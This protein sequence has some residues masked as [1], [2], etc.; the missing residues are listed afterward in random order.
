MH[1]RFTHTSI[2]L[3]VCALLAALS[4]LVFVFQAQGA[5]NHNP[6]GAV[7]VASCDVIAGWTCD[8]DS[9]STPLAV[10]LYKDG[11]YS[12]G[13]W[14]TSGTANGVRSD[15]HAVCGTNEAH[16]FSIPTPTA[17]KDGNQH[18]VNVYGINTGSEGSNT[19]LGSKTLTCPGTL[20]AWVPDAPAAIAAFA[21]S[22][23]GGRIK[24]I[25]TTVQGATSYEVSFDKT[26]WKDVGNTITYTFTNLPPAAT[27]SSFY[28]RAKSSGGVS[29]TAAES[30]PS[31]SSA[32]C[33]V[34]PS[35]S[36][37][38]D[39]VC[40][41]A[42]KAYYSSDASLAGT[43]CTTRISPSKDPEFLP[44]PGRVNWICPGENGGKDVICEATRSEFVGPVTCG[45]YA[46][47]SVTGST[48]GIVWGSG[49]YGERSDFGAAAVHAGLIQPGQTATIRRI[50]VGPST[51]TSSERNGVASSAY[52]QS[53]CAVTI[54]LAGAT[55]GGAQYSC[56]GTLPTNASS[57]TG[58][59]TG[60]TGNTARSF[61]ALGTSAKC[62]YSC[63]SG[64]TWS[65]SAC[66]ASVN[67]CTGTLPANAV[68]HSGD[69]TGLTAN[70][71]RAY[72]AVG[73][74][75]KCEFYCSAGY[76]WSGSSCSPS[77]GFSCTGHV[78]T[79]AVFYSNDDAGLTASLDWKNSATNTGRKCEFACTKT[80]FTSYSM[81]T[82]NCESPQTPN[83]PGPRQGESTYP[84]VD[85]VA[86]NPNPIG[87]TTITW[88]PVNNPR[89]CTLYVMELYT[90]LGVREL[91]R[92]DIDSSVSYPGGYPTI[93]IVNPTNYTMM[94]ATT[95]NGQVGGSVWLYPAARAY[96]AVSPST[97]QVAQNT[98]FKVTLDSE[99]A[100]KCRYTQKR[101]GVTIKDNVVIT[102]G[103]D[104]WSEEII[105]KTSDNTP[106]RR[107]FTY[108]VPEGQRVVDGTGDV[109]E[110]G[111]NC[112]PT[113]N[114]GGTGT[115]TGSTPAQVRMTVGESTGAT[116]DQGGLIPAGACT[117]RLS[118][119]NMVSGVIDIIMSPWR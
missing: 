82:G 18:T 17:L 107:K 67:S 59:E 104:G 92:V 44:G 83:G 116:I 98:A 7:D 84:R 113:W 14:L 75:A 99:F 105:A 68:T 55:T 24:L 39:G 94:C 63:N 69:T 60:L 58:D 103:V 22:T 37:G 10:H 52:A 2:L 34:T 57:Y 47:V 33:T 118:F 112:S 45:P 38:T 81:G 117:V 61:N 65:G 35:T 12:S 50:L 100:D 106:T 53:M 74:A 97:G 78:P 72:S 25:W 3:G 36:T 31:V 41:T 111:F 4:F 32:A 29:A 13:T 49:P 108:N 15:L 5:I 77:T 21:D 86:T 88:T 114:M 93:P 90:Q 80:G 96:A 1:L 76:S 42:A 16:A 110:W 9:L 51:L 66:V 101:D 91:G 71:P 27:F 19:L 102:N 115:S 48:G 11:T 85:M 62:E 56:T 40:G 70:T 64:Y 8:A 26:T 28:V 54:S 6:I 87:A 20:S 46:D 119:S 109:Y 89:L 95:N 79:N 43:F 30:G 73:T 23:C